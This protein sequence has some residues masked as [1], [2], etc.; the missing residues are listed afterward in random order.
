MS[1]FTPCSKQHKI[2]FE[3]IYDSGN[4]NQ[5]KLALCENCIQLDPAFQKNIIE[6]KEVE[7]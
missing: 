5:Q 2:K 6:L 1:D 7:Q 3:I 4:G